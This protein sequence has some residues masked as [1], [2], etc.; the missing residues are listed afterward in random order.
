MTGDWVDL[1]LAACGLLPVIAFATV[2]L[3]VTLCKVGNWYAHRRYVRTR[4]PCDRLAA[5]FPAGVPPMRRRP[6][7]RPVDH[8]PPPVEAFP[9]GEAFL[10]DLIGA[11]RDAAKNPVADAAVIAIGDGLDRMFRRLGPPPPELFDAA[12]T[13]PATGDAGKDQTP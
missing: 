5:R 12:T 7:I 1:T 9:T 10:A 11:R 13:E 6:S 8:T 3:Y 2:G 4:I